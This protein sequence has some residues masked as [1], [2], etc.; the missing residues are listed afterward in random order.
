M[1]VVNDL[2]D[3][4]IDEHEVLSDT[5]FIK[6]P[7]EVSEDL[8]HSVKDIHHIGRRHVLLGSCHKEDS[9]LLGV[10]VVYPIHILKT[11]LYE[12]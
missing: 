3:D 5:L 1:A 9:E 2:I 10:E 12:I 8:H 11:H 4:L 6:D 7:A